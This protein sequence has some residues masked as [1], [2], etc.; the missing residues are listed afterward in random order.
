MVLFFCG[1]QGG[2][3]HFENVDE[4]LKHDRLNERY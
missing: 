3:K 2:P 4:I 1:V